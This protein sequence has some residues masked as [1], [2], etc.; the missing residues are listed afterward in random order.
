MGHKSV[1]DQRKNSENFA[2]TTKFRNYADRNARKGGYNRNALPGNAK[3]N[4]LN[5]F[6]I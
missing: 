3:F 2:Q 4:K 5:I 1:A 6:I